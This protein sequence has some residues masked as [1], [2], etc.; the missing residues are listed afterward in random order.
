MRG[1]F[2]LSL[3]ACSGG[4][5]LVEVGPPPPRATQGLLSGPLCDGPRCAC[6]DVA[7]AD[8]GGVGV[9]TDAAHK[10]F[11]IRLTSPQELWATVGTVRLYKPA[12]P[13]E[14]CFYVDLPTG[15]TPVELRASDPNGAA[16][17][18]T[19]R[20]LGTN[21]KSFYDTF[22]FHCGVPGVCSLDELD[23]IK[24]ASGTKPK[25][26]L[27]PCGSTKVKAVTWTHSRAP[28]G[29]HPTDLIVRLRLEVYRF[30]PSKPHG[31]S[32]CGKAAN[33]TGND[34]RSVTSD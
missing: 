27:D 22:R 23:A 17:E 9:P 5:Q 14:S 24:T 10:R 31:D 18:W 20:E 13:A 12:S 11:E 34:T 7:A 1:A 30:A 3:M 25:R 2:L 21:T 28:D 8:D 4:A 15:E 26:V 33:S 29:I 19:I 6:R 16:G 32:S